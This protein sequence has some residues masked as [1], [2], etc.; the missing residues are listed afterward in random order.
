M[1]DTCRS[2]GE[3]TGAAPKIRRGWGGRRPGAGRKSKRQS[4]SVSA[5]A[6][7]VDDAEYAIKF[8][9]KLMRDETQ[10]IDLRLNAALEILDR[11]EQRSIL[12]V[13][14]ADQDDRGPVVRSLPNPKLAN[15]RHQG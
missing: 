12:S 10:S 6:A 1:G 11:A 14:V 8:L 5:A 15:G 13:N 7:D 2:A 9:A 4:T 3:G